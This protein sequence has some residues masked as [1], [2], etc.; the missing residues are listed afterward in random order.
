M[1]HVMQNNCAVFRTGEV[2]HEG[3]NLIHKVHGGIGDI[4]VSD[5]SL[6]WNSDLV[7]TLEFDNLIVQAVVTMDFGGESH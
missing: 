5:R 4:S 3:Q 7:E 6:I 1:Q 2:L